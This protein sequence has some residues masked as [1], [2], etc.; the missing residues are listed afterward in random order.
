MAETQWTEEKLQEVMAYLSEGKSAGQIALL[1]GISRN[2][3]IGKIHRGG[4]TIGRL[5]GFTAR[6]PQ[7]APRRP[8]PNLVVYRTYAAFAP[9]SP[10]SV[11]F[12]TPTPPPLATGNPC[13]LLDLT[14]DTCHWP[15][16]GDHKDQNKQYCGAHSHGKVYCE[17]H[18]FMAGPLYRRPVESQP[19]SSPPSASQ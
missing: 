4:E 3:I 8:R 14:K 9:E 10:M 7:R 13:S 18:T 11:K 12:E 5:N 16:W 17:G 15:L 19:A 1:T 2:A 6:H